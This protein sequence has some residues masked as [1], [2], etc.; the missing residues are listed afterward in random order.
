MPSTA[1]TTSPRGNRDPAVVASKLARLNDPP[2]KPL[3][4]LVRRIDAARD[5]ESTPWFDPDGGGVAA[6][7]LMLL[8]CP[9][10]KSSRARGS[11]II[12]LDNDDQTAENLFTLQQ[13]AGL[14]R[15]W[16][17]NWNIVPWYLPAGNRTANAS[18]ADVR[19]AAPWLSEVITLLP[20]LRVVV[21]MGRRAQQGWDLYTAAAGSRTD[22]ATA[23][24][25]HPSPLSIN[26]HPENRELIRAALR[27]AKGVATGPG[28]RRPRRV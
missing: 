14:A 21:L 13:E 8:E 27:E 16:A 26:P 15:S 19:R 18:A 7:V 20:R 17:V 10:A 23:R 4:D 11:G 3:N 25:P 22:L 24:C 9:G 12:S 6:R 5:E 1:F 2:V 28:I